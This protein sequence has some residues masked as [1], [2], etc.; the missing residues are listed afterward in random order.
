MFIPHA[1]RK[2]R[3][4]PSV[5]ALYIKGDDLFHIQSSFYEDNEK[6]ILEDTERTLIMAVLR[7]SMGESHGIS[8]W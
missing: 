6:P 5:L 2:I 1:L 8:F 3:A 4:Y 7:S